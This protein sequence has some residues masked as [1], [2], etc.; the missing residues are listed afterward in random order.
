MESGIAYDVGPTTVSPGVSGP[1]TEVGMLDGAYACHEPCGSDIL[2]V[3]GGIDGA[4]CGMASVMG[5][6]LKG[7]DM[8]LAGF[9]EVEDRRSSSL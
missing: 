6:L 8:T 1:L 2:C 3:N 9:E 4:P 5:G 7:E